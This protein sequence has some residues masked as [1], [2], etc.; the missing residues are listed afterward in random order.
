MSKARDL[1]KLGSGFEI[2]GSNSRIDSDF[3]LQVFKKFIVKRDNSSYLSGKDSDV[4]TILANNSPSTTTIRGDMDMR[5]DMVFHSYQKDSDRLRAYNET[6][7]YRL[8]SGKH[9]DS[10][11]ANLVVDTMIG[12]GRPT[13]YDATSDKYNEALIRLQNEMAISHMHDVNHDRAPVTGQYLRW[14]GDKY[15]PQDQDAEGNFTIDFQSATVALSAVTDSDSILGFSREIS[16]ANA[17]VFLNG[18]ILGI[19]SDAFGDGRSSGGTGTDN[20]DSDSDKYALIDY[21]ILANVTNEDVDQ[22]VSGPA[23]ALRLYGGA[24]HEDEITV[25]SPIDE[26]I[27]HFYKNFRFADSDF[28]VYRKARNN[29]DGSQ[30]TDTATGNVHQ[31]FRMIDSD[32]YLDSDMIAARVGGDPLIFLNGMNINQRFGDFYFYDSDSDQRVEYNAARMIAFDSD[33]YLLDSDELVA[34][35]IRNVGPIASENFETL[36]H[37][38]TVDDSDHPGFATGIVNIP[39]LSSANDP[40]HALVFLNGHLLANVPA[41]TYQ[42]RA[43][44]SEIIFTD[45]LDIGD[46]VS[47]YNFSGPTTSNT[48]LG[49]LSNVDRGVDNQFEVKTGETLVFTGTEWTHQFKNTISETPVTAAWMRV[50]FDSDNGPNPNRIINSA[51]FGFD[52][53]QLKYSRHEEGV[54]YFLLDSDVVPVKE[55]QGSYMS[56]AVST[57]APQGQPIFSS[58]DAQGEGAYKAPGPGADSETGLTIDVFGGRPLVANPNNR[59]IRVRTWDQNGNSIDPIQIN[60]Q[61]WFKRSIG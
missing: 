32:I 31:T 58:V 17:L 18:H 30:W 40:L 4:F 61:V 50:T 47:V 37:T 1:S 2:D 41:L 19:D 56:M 46:Q 11:F 21:R 38:F 8:R 27:A 20:Q 55:T 54:Y 3:V 60:V 39:F 59:A 53:D 57:C 7:T 22:I 48:S 15:E 5:G 6:D 33:Q 13:Q 52:S 29:W 16:N 25:I 44:T 12:H 51:T 43:S 49:N 10:D 36:E 28:A 34:V 26:T 45:P 24:Q 42:V 14:N 9:F 35:W 23:D